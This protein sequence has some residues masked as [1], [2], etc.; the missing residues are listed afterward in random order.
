M[1]VNA[2]QSA[3]SSQST[4]TTTGSPQDLSDTF[5]TLLAT[6]LKSQDP[7]APMDATQFVGQLVDFNSLSQLVKIRELI[8]TSATTGSQTSTSAAGGQ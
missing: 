8:E 6:E 2:T 5:M 7:T 4:S 3:S 1:Q